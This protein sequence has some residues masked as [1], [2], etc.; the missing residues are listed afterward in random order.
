MWRAGCVF[1]ASFFFAALAL[2]TAVLGDDKYRQDVERWRQKHEA[3]LRADDGWLSVCGLCW[4]RAGETGIGSDPANDIV[5]PA[6]APAR[7]GTLTLQERGWR[8]QPA[9]GV[10]VLR[11]GTRFEGGVVRSDADDSPDTLAVG[12]VK[13]LLLKRGAR[14][15]VRLKD[16]QNP[17]R[18]GFAGLRWYPVS[19]AWRIEAR[20][21]PDRTATKLVLDTVIGEAEVEE[22]SGH[23]VFERGGKEYHLQ[24]ARTKKGLLWFVFRDGTSGRFTHPGAR[25]LYAEP[26]RGDIVVLDFNKAVNLPCAYSPYTTCPLAPR[27]NRLSLAVEAGELK[28]EA[29]PPARTEAG[30]PP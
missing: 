2:A 24:A 23:A 5:L 10:T 18:T 19:E 4:L 26:P 3:D 29:R 25:Q 11:N 21:V 12:D 20:F 22:S 27:Q 17:L 7:V 6:H 8:F 15:A 16:R 28:Y 14:Y 30:S 13:L 1:L 9:A